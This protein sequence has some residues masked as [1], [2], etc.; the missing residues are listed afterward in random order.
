MPTPLRWTA[1]AFVVAAL[2]T[3]CSSGSANPAP[4]ENGLPA[5]APPTS[6]TVTTTS[7]TDTTPD[8]AAS[9][10]AVDEPDSPPSTPA[11]EPVTGQDASPAADDWGRPE[12]G[13]TRPD[14]AY[15]TPVT[16]MT[17]A[18]GTRF[19]RNTYSRRNPEN[20]DGTLFISYHGDATYNVSRV[21]D[22]TL[23]RVT[24]IHPD[25]EPQWHPTNP[26]RIRHVAG[27][28]VSVGRLQLFETSVSTGDTTVIADLT[29]RLQAR[30]PD[31]GYMIDRAEGAPSADGMRWAW[32]VHD[33]DED[34]VG[35]VHYDLATDTILGTLDVESPDDDRLDWVSASPSGEHVVAGWWSRTVVFD[36][37]LSNPRL[38]VEG[39]EHSDL[40]LGA[41][42]EDVYV[43]IDFVDSGWAIATDLDTLEETRLF[44]LYDNANTSIH[45]SGKAYDRPGWVVASTY[46]CKEDGSPWSCEKV[47]AVNVHTTE[48]VQ[49][50]HTYNCGAEYWTETHAA[51]N[52]DLSRVWFN[53]DGGSCGSDAEVYRLDVAP[54]G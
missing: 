54:L 44:D 46:S 13:V 25:G 23:V 28:N 14:P 17:S 37:D 19:N 34:V 38:L 49:L 33:S 45:F 42:G 2:I 18:D 47:F 5:S 29:E 48:I 20:A 11:L 52:R 36:A 53:S 3:S 9:S 26:D 31:A 30:F 8:A 21:D 4:A 32:I 35:L 41:S 16:R 39:A 12:L 10:A 40:L 7:T 1:A 51:T 27:P 50:A 6:E 43:W 24:D 15:G 22:G